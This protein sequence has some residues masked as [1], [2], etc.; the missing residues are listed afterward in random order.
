MINLSAIRGGYENR[1]NVSR[2]ASGARYLPEKYQLGILTHYLDARDFEYSTEA[3]VFGYPLDILA[4][5]RDATIAIEMKSANSKRGFEQARRN[6][7]FVDYSFLSIWDE[8]ITE[9]LIQR[10]QGTEIG[11][12]SVSDEVQFISP[13]KICD[14]SFYPSDAIRD[15]VNPNV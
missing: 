7:E 9:N 11:L 12:I 10:V 1:W 6:A 13:P 14:K 5:K 15:I 8:N 3:Q 4:C 2:S